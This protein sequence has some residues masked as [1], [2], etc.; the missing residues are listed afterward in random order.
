MTNNQVNKSQTRTNLQNTNLQ[1]QYNLE[2]RTFA[3]ALR[4]SRYAS[5]VKK[6]LATAEYAKQLIRSSASIAANYI[7]ANESLS[8]KDFVFRIRISLKEAKE[9]RLWLKLI[10]AQSNNDQS[11]KALI[12]E[13]TE[14]V[15]IFS[16]IVTKC[17]R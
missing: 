2:E 1:S 16:S 14:L 8:K 17:K 12:N 4:C 6:T 15:K 11:S 10:Q 13:A 5:S 3:F 9:T 7:E